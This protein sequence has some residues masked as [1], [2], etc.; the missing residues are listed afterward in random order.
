MKKVSRIICAL[1]T[2]P[3][4]S[5]ASEAIHTNNALTNN[6]SNNS[7]IEYYSSI[8]HLYQNIKPIQGLVNDDKKIKVIRDVNENIISMEWFSNS[9]SNKVI[10]RDFVYDKNIDS[11]FA[12]AIYDSK[13]S[14]I[15]ITRDW[16]GRIPLYFFSDEKRFI[17]SSELKA[18]KAIKNITV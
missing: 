8:S 11:L 14:K 1:F 6:Q 15:F 7:S 16:P 5:T 18:F 9:K 2:I 4:I 10:K 13:K 12:L 17:F 3:I